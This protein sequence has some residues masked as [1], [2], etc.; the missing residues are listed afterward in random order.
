MQIDYFLNLI[1][2]QTQ[3]MVLPIINYISIMYPQAILNDEYS[4]KSKIPT[5]RLDDKFV[6]IGCRKHYISI[7]FDS[8]TAVEII[9]ANTIYCRAQKSCVN[10]SY[11]RQL[12]YDAIYKGIDFCLND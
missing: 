10:F 11:R 1:D 6:A 8:A 7:Y 9:C 3:E 12:P 2:K 5:W 4:I